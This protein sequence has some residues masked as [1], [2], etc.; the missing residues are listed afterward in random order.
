MKERNCTIT[1]H[2]IDKKHMHDDVNLSQ[3][4]GTKRVLEPPRALGFWKTTAA[5]WAP[6]PA[7]GG[8]FHRR[9]V[10]VHSPANAKLM[11]LAHNEDI[12]PPG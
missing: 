3:D 2:K 7:V 4:S 5:F 11:P 9:W 1:G 6:A 12:L 10:A 8:G